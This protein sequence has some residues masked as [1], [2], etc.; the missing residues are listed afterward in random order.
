M[1]VY[2]DRG[3]QFVGPAYALTVLRSNIALMELIAHGNALRHHCLRSI[4]RS[5]RPSAALNTG[6]NTRA[7]SDGESGH[8][9][10]KRQNASLADTF[11]EVA[12]RPV[13]V[14]HVLD[15]SIG[16][17]AEVIPP[18]GPTAFTWDKE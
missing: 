10:R 2:H 15:P 8:L 16:I 1:C 12:V 7:S 11:V 3:E 4:P 18:I 9:R 17:L 6:I 5:M 14:G 13:A